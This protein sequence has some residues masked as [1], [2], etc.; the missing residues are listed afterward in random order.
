LFERS[1]PLP[2]HARLILVLALAFIATFGL[3]SLT[4][5]DADARVVWCSGDPTIIVNGSIV[6][7]TVHVPLDRLRD[8]DHVEVIFHVPSNAKVTALINDS[9]LIPAKMRYVRDLP[10]ERGLLNGTT[11]VV[12]VVG[13]H[14]G[15]PMPIAATTI[16]T[17]RGTSLWTQG[18]TEKPLVVTTKGLLNLPVLGLFR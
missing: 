1:Y 13:H 4:S 6:S 5:R 8:V 11:V 15:A 18:T 10:A 2:S 7:V 12:E 14:K 3:S 16:A 17:G 9:I